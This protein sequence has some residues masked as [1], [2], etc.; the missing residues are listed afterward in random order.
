MPPWMAPFWN[1]EVVRKQALYIVGSSVYVAVEHTGGNQTFDLSVMRHML[2]RC[3]TTTTTRTAKL[4]P[5]DEGLNPCANKGSYHP[6]L[7]SSLLMPTRIILLLI[8]SLSLSAA[9]PFLLSLCLSEALLLGICFFKFRLQGSNLKRDNFLQGPR[10]RIFSNSLTLVTCS[11]AT[12]QRLQAYYLH[13]LVSLLRYI[14]G[15][16]ASPLQ[17]PWTPTSVPAQMRWFS[18]RLGI[19]DLIFSLVVADP[20]S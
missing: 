16:P 11:S 17:G 20:P 15:P 4:Q 5:L 10:L 6:F 8:I 18:N 19:R 3:A 1:P 13:W 9:K 14:I 2:Y 12:A 7:V